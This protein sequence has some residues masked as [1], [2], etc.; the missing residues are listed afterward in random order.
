MGSPV[1][2]TDQSV[3]VEPLPG[4]PEKS[5]REE[6]LCARLAG[7]VTCT[8]VPAG[9][10]TSQGVAQSLPSTFTVSP[11]MVLL[12]VRCPTGVYV[13]VRRTP[14]VSALGGTVKSWA[15]AAPLD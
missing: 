15:A 14:A 3:E 12:T 6:S 7:A 11:E 1:R 2:V 13:A 9:R 8:E 10:C 5:E 4:Q